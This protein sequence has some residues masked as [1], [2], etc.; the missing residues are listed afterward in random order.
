[1]N[2]EDIKLK[3]KFLD[4][5]ERVLKLENTVNNI[6]IVKENGWYGIGIEIGMNEND[7]IER[8]ENVV[9]NTKINYFSNE[10]HK[11]LELI[12]N[13]IDMLEQFSLICYNLANE[14]EEKD[15]NI[16][17]IDFA[18]TWWKKW[19]KLLGNVMK[20]QED[21]ALLAEL[22]SLN[23]LLQEDRSAVYSSVATHDIETCDN[24]YEIKSTTEK[25]DSKIHVNSQYQ[26]ENNS[27]HPLKMIFVRLERSQIGYSIKDVLDELKNKGYDVEEIN[28]THH[29]GTN[30][31]NEKFRILESRMYDINDEFPKIT[32]K[33]LK[34]EKLPKGIIKLE[35]TI[36]LNEI[37]YEAIDLSYK[38][39]NDT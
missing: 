9:L 19:K 11:L 2:V 22:L 12:T 37:E 23:Y 27:G 15:T 13:Q 25:Y 21:Y 36:D 30:A 7:Y 35:Y 34:D 17:A 39:E 3:M 28:K 8:F 29:I 1:M 4:Q 10:N 33:N 6:Y 31:L 24:S 32:E 38:K 14:F 16:N 26:L 18:D 5:G 20:S